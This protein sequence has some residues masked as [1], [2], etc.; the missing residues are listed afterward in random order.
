MRTLRRV[1]NVLA[2][3]MGIVLVIGAIFAD[4]SLPVQI[5][6]VLAGLLLAE[7]GLRRLGE[8]MLPDARKYHP[9]RRETDHFMALVRQINAA[10]VAMEEGDEAGSRFAL[11]EVRTEMHRSV[12]RLAQYAGRVGDGNPDT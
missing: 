11:D 12:E 4:T 7:A 2:P 10:A 6:L 3:A 9:L 8:P 1:I 5:F